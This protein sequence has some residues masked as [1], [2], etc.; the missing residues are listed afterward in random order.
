[1]HLISY[2]FLFTLKIQVWFSLSVVYSPA[3]MLFSITYRICFEMLKKE[4]EELFNNFFIVDVVQSNNRV[5]QSN[6][7][8]S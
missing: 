6:N 8:V 4:H 3:D 2:L 7:Q 5:I 1:M